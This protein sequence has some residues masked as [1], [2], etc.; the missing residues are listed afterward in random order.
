M[1]SALSTAL[2]ALWSVLSGF[3]VELAK[4]FIYKKVGRQEA[5]IKN[6]ED[7][8]RRAEGESLLREEYEEIEQRANRYRDGRAESLAER[9]RAHRPKARRQNDRV[10]PNS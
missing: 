8:A 4:Y 7:R 5:E 10:S 1:N 3:F 6:L 2:K 9:L